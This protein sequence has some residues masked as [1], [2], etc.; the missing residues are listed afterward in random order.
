MEC[1]EFRRLCGIDPSS[2]DAAYRE[3]AESCPGCGE[4][5]RELQALDGLILQALKIDV[6]QSSDNIKA[7]SAPEPR[8]AWVRPRWLGLAASLLLAVGV[9]AGIWVTLPKDSLAGEVV[10]HILH[11]PKA[12]SESTVRVASEDIYRVMA[13]AGY[14]LDEGVGLVTYS[15]TCVFRGYE[16][17]HLVIQGNNGPI[18]VM[19][20][21]DIPLVQ[22]VAVD[23]SGFSGSIIPFD[24]GSLAIVGEPGE[25]EIGRMTRNLVEGIEPNR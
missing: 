20:L 1:L 10:E 4:Y 23:E 9:A 14:A 5:A 22:P 13:R 21:P 17:P 6:P 12:L 7:P 19:L 2:A 18:T 15:R 11:E 24:K 25:T 8:P 16:V 3:H